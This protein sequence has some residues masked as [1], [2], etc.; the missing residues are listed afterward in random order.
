MTATL[1]PE[2]R[3][4][5]EK[6]YIPPP[7]SDKRIIELDGIRGVAV[8]FILIWHYVGIPWLPAGIELH[9]DSWIP[10][11]KLSLIFFRSGVD[12]FFVLSGF[13]IGG[14]LIDQRET[15]YY[16]RTFFI[17]RLCRIFP[18]YYTLLL[19]YVVARF[20]GVRGQLFDGPIPLASYM[21]MTQNYFMVGIGTYG[22][23]W[24]GATWSLAIEEQFYLLFPFIVRYAKR[25][26]PWVL[27]IGIVG[28]SLLRI[29]C[30]HHF[31]ND[32][33][34]YMW[35]PCRLDSLCLGVLTAYLLRMPVTLSFICRRRRWL[36]G[37]F[38]ALTAGAIGLDAAL[39][40]DIGYHMSIWGHTLLAPLY[41]S[42]ILLAVLYEGRGCIAFL[43]V[44]P[45]VFLGRISYGV[46][47]VHGIVLISVFA[48]AGRTVRLGNLIDAGLL[49]CALTLT[50][51]I[52]L[53]SYR[54]LERPFLQIGKD[55]KYT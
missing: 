6:L 12:L 18:L 1:H 35:L 50:I 8:L 49:A 39:A 28:A 51:A 47:L 37:I 52:C 40:R 53:F 20:A 31:N 33:A 19:I 17:R 55:K 44:R 30:Y 14:I 45:L 13:L 3:P 38:A 26:L 32:A 41:A 25:A 11:F 54:W 15:K 43:R 16:Y 36:A 7:S 2:M 42:A 22:A 46:Y 10:S 5:S 24:L 34:A 27:L 29:W 9:P 21:T 48:V 4:G 23:A